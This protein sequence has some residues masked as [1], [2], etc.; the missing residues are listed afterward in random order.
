MERL[1]ERFRVIA[2]DYPGFGHS[3]TPAP[4]TAGGSFVYSFAALATVI[5]AFCTRLG[6]GRFFMYLFDF[7]GPI[8]MRLLE[9]R[10][11]SIAGLIVQNANIYVEGL[12]A[13]AA[14]L[15]K[16]TPD[17]PGA[18]EQALQMLTL[19]MT[20]FQ[21]LQGARDPE[22][23]SPDGWTLDQHFID[24]PGRKRVLTELILDY[25]T[26]VA[27]YETWQALLRKRQPPSLLVWGCNDPLF[28]EAGARAYLRDLP[29]AEL[30]LFD[31]GHFA[32]EEHVDDIAA[33]IRT[34]IA[35]SSMR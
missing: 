27:R 35:R 10:P 26:N 16:L 28:P 7:G 8:G 34:F 3:D 4:S 25:H 13:N 32:L 6:L 30:H 23:I 17:I 15:V 1:S 21:Y 14:Q 33:L 31:T 24:Q 19:Q 5:E 2:P 18:V 29:H 20:R 22:R 9:R 12:S 11:E